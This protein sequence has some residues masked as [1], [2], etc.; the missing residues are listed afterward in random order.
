[1]KK[2]I[3]II[4]ITVLIL[5]SQTHRAIAQPNVVPTYTQVM[6]NGQNTGSINL[7]VTLGAPPYVY[8]WSNG[9]TT[10][11]NSNLLAG[12]YNVT[13]TDN[14]SAVTTGSYS[15]TEPTL[16]VAAANNNS[17]ICEGSVLNLTAIPAAMTTYAWSGPAAYSSNSQNPMVSGSATLVNAG[18]YTLTVTNSN[19][20][21]ATASTMVVVNPLNTAGV[22]SSNPTLCMNTALTPITHLTIGATGISGATGLPSGVTANWAANT[23]TISGT[24]T[25][26]GVFN[27][28]IPLMGGCLG[29]NATGTITVLNMPMIT[30]N[31]NSPVCE[32]AMLNIGCD[33]AGM[34]TY[35]WS[36]PVGFTSVTQN[37]FVS[38]SANLPMAGLYSVT[39]VN[40][41][42]CMGTADVNVTIRTK[43]IA[44]AI[45]NSPV[46]EGTNL[47]LTGGDNGMSSYSWFG[48]SAFM[49]A[50]QNP[51]IMNTNLTMSGMY[52]LIVTDLFGCTNSASTIVTIDM[53]NPL[54]LPFVMVNGDTIWVHPSDNH[55]GII[56]GNYSIGVTGATS[57]TDGYINQNQILATHGAI[58]TA[59]KVCFDLDTFGFN[60]WYL[61]AIDE[62]DTMFQFQGMIGVF[63]PNFYWSSTEN[64]NLHAWAKD[65]NNG[66][67]SNNGKEG[68]LYKVRCVRK[69][70]SFIVPS[71]NSNITH[72]LCKGN[73]NGSIN[74]SVMNGQA[75]YLYSWSNAATTED[76]SLLSA[77]NYSVTV[78]DAL[79]NTVSASYMITEPLEM[80]VTTIPNQTIGYCNTQILTSNVTNGT[81]I[82]YAWSPVV[83]LSSSNTANPTLMVSTLSIGSHIY[84]LTVTDVNNCIAST[85]T[86]I[87]IDA[88]VANV[89]TNINT[90]FCANTTLSAS[91]VVGSPNVYSWSPST[92]LNNATILSPTVNANMLS[93][94][95][96]NYS[97]IVMDIYGCTDTA[98]LT[99]NVENISVSLMNDTT[100]SS[101]ISSL[102]IVNMTNGMITHFIWSP[103]TGLSDINVPLPTL[104]TSLLSSGSYTYAI[105]AADIYGCYRH[106]T[107]TITKIPKANPIVETQVEMCIENTLK[108]SSIIGSSY[109]WNTGATNQ[110]IDVSPI[111]NTIYILNYSDAFGCSISDTIMAKVNGLVNFNFSKDLIDTMKVNF[112]SMAQGSVTSYNWSF[113]DGY[114]SSLENPIHAFTKPGIYQACIKTFE[115]LSNCQKSICKELHIGSAAAQCKAEFGYIIT[116]SINF[117]VAF[118]TASI[119]A[120][121]YYW[122]FGD[123]KTSVLAN[124]NHVYTTSG[125][126]TV[127]LSIY[128][129]IS[130]CQSNFCMNVDLQFNLQQPLA[131][132]DYMV[133]DS[134][135]TLILTNLSS[136]YTKNYWTFGDGNYSKA[137]DTIYKYTKAGIYDVC[138]NTYNELSGLMNQKCNSIK[139]GNTNCNVI[140]DYTFFVDNASNK[141][142]FT[143]KSTGT[144]HTFYWTFGDGASKTTMNP[145]HV[146]AKPGD[147]LVSLSILDTNNHC[148]SNTSRIVQVG[149]VNCIANYDYMITNA[150]SN[151]LS[152]KANSIGSNL[153]YYWS[154]GDGSY[155]NLM[156]P[157][158]KYGAAGT[159]PV[160]L[161]ISSNSLN[162]V[163]R[164]EKIIEVANTSCEANFAVF[165]DSTSNTV[166]VNNLS[167]GTNLKYNWIFGDGFT[168]TQVNPAHQFKASGYYSI[169]LVV[170]NESTSCMHAKE[171]KMLI[172]NQGN[173]C[174]A[175]FIFVKNNSSVVFSN[176]SR[177]KNIMGYYWNF[178]DQTGKAS[179]NDTVIHNY[180]PGYYNVCLNAYGKN[181]VSDMSCQTIKIDPP[182]Q[183]D[184]RANFS[185]TIDSSIKRGRF[186]DK[187]YG[188][189]NTWNWLSNEVSISNIKNPLYDFTDTGYY[190]IKL[191][192]TTI[193]GCSSNQ[194][195]LVRIGDNGGKIKSNFACE[196]DSLKQKAAGYPVD[197]IGISHGDAAKLKWNF[198]D[199]TGDSTT[200]N[201]KH[202]FAQAGTYWVCYTISD[203]I[204]GDE[205][206]SCD[207][208]RVGTANLIN[209]LK[210]DVFTVNIRPNPTS[211]VATIIYTIPSTT[212]VNLDVVNLAGNTINQLVNN[213]K[214]EGKQ[215]I[216][217]DCSKTPSGFYYIRL[218]VESNTIMK[219]V[220]IIK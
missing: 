35:T 48:P 214:Q 61:P 15:I 121:S 161:T 144:A 133:I 124:P 17:P 92:A 31:S 87:T 106:D 14:I 199:G 58:A 30:T 75:P 66:I 100:I 62:M 194:Y 149:A 71:L 213:E 188:S 32:G 47:F 4:S 6:C 195:K 138:L 72:P 78:T 196:S 166:Y 151:K 40:S 89:P 77:A 73:A 167:K 143:N 12:M 41:Y 56:W 67:K 176:I 63:S 98:S 126:Y 94:G 7:I 153:T 206:S 192:V 52:S 50:M 211:D 10:M 132:F 209:E 122:N 90:G 157:T 134:S 135:R 16:L 170:R 123:G 182:A 142:V 129:S 19:A 168:S 217:W 177:G 28:N 125:L 79:L 95:S 164:I 175:K 83:G 43:P 163:N 88:I 84:T 103:S 212:I 86:T 101:C 5:L 160:S 54:T 179:I 20:C 186:S 174:H 76:I 203:P 150:D 18:N 74:L 11:N 205:S 137:F 191:K 60:D 42:G 210:V 139:V 82:A 141:A 207:S 162:C 55:S 53:N 102:P 127:C 24:P 36:G 38:G 165:V 184:C 112:V 68:N 110:S 107:I 22:A 130:K 81:A 1:M 147:Y 70:Q 197:F 104:N 39:A 146:Y 136:A 37:P 116:D 108:I 23:I 97:L 187:S 131:N 85:S 99:L 51:L 25:T 220:V 21:I 96:Y 91:I 69:K 193:D 173:D 215:E 59:A 200:T 128:D 29:T 65:F 49:S 114:T 154:F 180:L 171:E 190:V 189:V 44:T 105:Q 46:I 93:P 2:K 120:K 159:Y 201:P 219:K 34:T 13:V 3:L 178:G 152:F 45:S 202:V 218:R 172:A 145:F 158:K 216:V 181:G 155:S 8:S 80:M 140:T 33:Q 208:I 118:S 27:Y 115:N 117:T 183:Q 148:T 9:V 57:F 198:G 109:L 64:S 204:T 156:N 111:S 169:A 119:N 26:A 113:G 185:Y